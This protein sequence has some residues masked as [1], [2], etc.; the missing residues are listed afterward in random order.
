MC[1][2]WGFHHEM[3]ANAPA[4]SRREEGGGGSKLCSE[5]HAEE[6]HGRVRDEESAV[7]SSGQR[8]SLQTLSNPTYL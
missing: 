5:S 3:F 4:G 1:L 6:N 2:L 7:G 8:W